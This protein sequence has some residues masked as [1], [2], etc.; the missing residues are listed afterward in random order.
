M[1]NKLLK[2]L[3][4]KENSREFILKCFHKELLYKKHNNFLNSP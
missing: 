1:L 4:E 2:G 3:F